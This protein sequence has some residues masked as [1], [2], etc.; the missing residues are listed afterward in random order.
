[1]RNGALEAGL[2]VLPVEDAGLDVRVAVREE[3]LYISADPKRVEDAD[4]DRAARA[5]RR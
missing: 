4:H 2:I 1:M 3:L 5:R